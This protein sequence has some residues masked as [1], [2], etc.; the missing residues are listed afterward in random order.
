MNAQVYQLTN[1]ALCEDIPESFEYK[2]VRMTRRCTVKIKLQKMPRMIVNRSNIR[3]EEPVNKE[4]SEGQVQ[5]H[6]NGN[7]GIIKGVI[8]I[9]YN[10][11]RVAMRC[12]NCKRRTNAYFAILH[13][14]STQ[15]N[16][17]LGYP[18]N[19]TKGPGVVK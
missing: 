1:Y 4:I 10:Y 2:E 16:S 13:S 17:K 3:I 14:H 8:N 11:I 12:R 5:V 19:K 6:E 9:K 15:Y 7:N 18:E